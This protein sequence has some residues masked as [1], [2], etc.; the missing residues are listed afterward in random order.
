VSTK[1]IGGELG[2]VAAAPNGKRS[3]DYAPPA[4]SEGFPGSAHPTD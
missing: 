1:A 3:G 2:A 4:Q